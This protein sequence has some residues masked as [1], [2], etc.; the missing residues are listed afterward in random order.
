MLRVSDHALVRWLDRA[1]GMDVEAVRL[2]LAAGLDRAA[3]AARALDQAEFK[4]KAAGLT[5]VVV[6]GVV[7]TITGGSR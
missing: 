2:A 6:D 7:V 4:I 3:E 1:G 5:F